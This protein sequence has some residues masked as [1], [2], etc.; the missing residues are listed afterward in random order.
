MQEKEFEIIK[1]YLS[2]HRYG[3]ISLAHDNRACAIPVSYLVDGLELECRLPE[4]SEAAFLLE[5]SP[6]VTVIIPNDAGKADQCW[7][8]YS[9]VAGESQQTGMAPWAGQPGSYRSVRLKPLR[10]DL[11]D[12]RRGW[13]ARDTLEL[14][15]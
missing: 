2:A 1:G 6:E 4:W 11:I 8:E 9:A 10:I 13:G 7:L 14:R 15:R 5:N 3:I 12:M